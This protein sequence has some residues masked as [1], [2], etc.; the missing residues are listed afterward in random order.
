MID[1]NRGVTIRTHAATGMQVYMYKDT[2]GIYMNAHEEEVAEKLAAQAGYPV[3]I[4]GKERDRKALIAD[5]I[6]KINTAF[7]VTEGKVVYEKGGFKVL[8]LGG[9]RFQVLSP[10]GNIMTD[11]AVTLKQAK[12]VVDAAAK[13]EE[14]DNG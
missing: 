4:L 1:R 6:A 8:G 10:E 3:E 9:D 12:K 13:A 2:P 11:V 14:A 5:E 7:G